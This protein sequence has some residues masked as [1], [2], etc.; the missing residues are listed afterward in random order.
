MVKFKIFMHVLKIILFSIILS[1]SIVIHNAQGYNSYHEATGE[2][3]V[4]DNDH[5]PE[6]LGTLIAHHPDLRTLRINNY[7]GLILTQETIELLA[8]FPSLTTL[9]LYGNVLTDPALF[10]LLPTTIQEIL[11]N[12]MGQLTNDCFRHLPPLLHTLKISH[13]PHI[14]GA[15]FAE[16]PLSV[17]TLELYNFSRL[18]N[19]GFRNLPPPLHALTLNTCIFLTDNDLKTLPPTIE[20]LELNNCP[21]LTDAG[22]EHLP[23]SIRQL[24]IFSYNGAITDASIEVLRNLPLLTTLEIHGCENLSDAGLQWLKEERQQLTITRY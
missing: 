5:Q 21:R 22:L 2:L 17:T 3:F 14:T 16:L 4:S 20:V 15:V 9:S 1:H 7:S 11:L 24:S 10:A 13:C 23:T 12:S 6:D 8:S 18:D 19:N